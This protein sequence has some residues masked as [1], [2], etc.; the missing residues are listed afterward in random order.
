[1][2]I[3]NEKQQATEKQQEEKIE[4]EV[5]DNGDEEEASS[6][7]GLVV[8][9]VPGPRLT[10]KQ[11]IEKDKDD[12]SLRKW[13]AQ[14]LGSLV[15]DSIDKMEP[16]VMFHSI[17]IISDDC[18]ETTTPLSSNENHSSGVLFTLKEGSKYRFKLTFSVK[19][20]IVSGLKYSNTVWKGAMKVDKVKGMLGS[21]A[22][23]EEAYV[24]IMDEET[25]PSGIFARGTYSAKLKFED[26]DNR[27]HL[28]FNYT[29]QIKKHS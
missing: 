23:Q 5:S 7:G 13:K 26:D 4:E 11:Q 20:N 19:H 24:Q 9:F 22:P 10:L 14:L 25:A 16:D 27:C 12:E 28:D 8:D 17:G 6:N 21:F 3:A 29:F 15:E 18:E 1:M 2:E